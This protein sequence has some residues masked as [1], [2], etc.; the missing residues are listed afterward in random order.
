MV[1]RIGNDPS[2]FYWLMFWAHDEANI[3]VVV[4]HSNACCT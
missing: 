2:F 4:K 1:R 3:D